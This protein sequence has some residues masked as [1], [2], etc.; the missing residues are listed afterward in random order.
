MLPAITL[1]LRHIFPRRITD[2]EENIGC[3]VQSMKINKAALRAAVTPVQAHSVPL[4][5]SLGNEDSAIS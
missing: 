3:R 1:P 2:P 5:L 4:F